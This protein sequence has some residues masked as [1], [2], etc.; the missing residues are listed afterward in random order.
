M[1]VKT[2]KIEDSMINYRNLDSLTKSDF[3][4]Q[5]VSLKLPRNNLG[6]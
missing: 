6:D 1:N 5:I 2:L 3:A 4:Q